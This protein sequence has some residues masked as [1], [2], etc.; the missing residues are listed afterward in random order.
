MH[1]EHAPCHH[2]PARILGLDGPAKIL[3]RG[4][5]G[6]RRKPQKVRGRRTSSRPGRSRERHLLRLQSFDVSHDIADALLHRGVLE[7]VERLKEG[8]PQ[9]H[10]RR[11]MR[12]GTIAEPQNA[13]YGVRRYFPSC[14]SASCVKSVGATFIALAAG[15]WPLP[16]A[17]WQ[18][19]NI[20]LP[21]AAFVCW[22]AVFLSS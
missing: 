18:G 3:L 9:G 4:I 20:S 16:S 1:S 14:V 11:V 6:W 10:L 21:E 2:T 8:T 12:P 7:L 15:P 5:R 17:P 19:V 22:I 13:G